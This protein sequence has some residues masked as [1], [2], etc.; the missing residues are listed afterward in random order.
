MN[1][2]AIAFISHGDKEEDHTVNQIL[3]I[4]N[5]PAAA[6]Q[7]GLPPSWGLPVMPSYG[8]PTYSASGRTEY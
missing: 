6:K 5:L 2:A 7:L 3:A 1:G 4:G 8:G